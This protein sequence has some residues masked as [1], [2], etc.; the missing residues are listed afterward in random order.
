MRRNII[1]DSYRKQRFDLFPIFDFCHFSSIPAIELNRFLKI[2]VTAPVSLHFH[3]NGHFSKIRRG[4]KKR[5]RQFLNEIEKENISP[6]VRWLCRCAIKWELNTLPCPALSVSTTT[7]SSAHCLTHTDFMR[8]VIFVTHQMN[9]VQWENKQ[10]LL[11]SPYIIVKTRTH[12]WHIS[13]NNSSNSTKR[14]TRKKT[15]E[16]TKY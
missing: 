10:Y 3:I 16:A 5:L 2:H 6:A 1:E 15:F 9:I 7:R 11:R 8:T 13:S 14:A 4:I 12:R